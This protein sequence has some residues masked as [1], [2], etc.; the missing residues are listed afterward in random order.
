MEKTIYRISFDYSD[1]DGILINSHSQELRVITS[2]QQYALNDKVKFNVQLG[3]TDDKRDTVNYNAI[4]QTLARNPTY[5]VRNPDGSLFEVKDWEYENPVGILTERENNNAG[6][7][8]FGNLGIDIYPIKSVKL[9]VTGGINR[10]RFLNGSYMPSYSFPMEKEGVS[11]SAIR[12][13]GNSIRST[14]ESTL[15]WKKTLGRHNVDL[16]GGYGYEYFVTEEFYASNSNFISDDV[17][18]NNL[19]MGTFLAEGRADMDSYKGESKLA[20]FFARAVY[21][22]ANKYFLSASIRR[23]GSSKFGDNRK[24]GTFPAISAAWDIS[25]EGFFEPLSGVFE[26]LK[27]RAGYGITGNQGM[28]AFYVPILRYDQDQGFFYYNGE[29]VRGYVPASNA[30]PNLQ[31]ETKAEFN[32]GLD[33]LSL[34]SRLSGAIDFYVRDTRDL[35][36]EY[37]VPVPPNLN[38]KMWANVGSMRNSG[39]EISINATPVKKS[40]FNWEVNFTFDY[41]KNKVMSIQ[42]DYYTLEYR[43]I[44]E[45]GA[46]GISA[47]THRLEEGE[48]IGNI[49]TYQFEKIDSLGKWVFADLDSSGGK[50]TGDRTVVG[51]GVPDFYLGMTNILR[52]G[53]FDLSFMLRGMFG[54]QIIN[55]KRIWHENPQFLPSNIM[56]SAMYT[57]LWD[58]PEF[59]SYYVENGDFV[60]VDNITLGYTYGFKNNKYL[61]SFRLYGT[62][63]NAFVFTKYT[64]LD[65]EVSFKGLEPGNDNRFD[66]PSV[67]TF[68]VGLNVKF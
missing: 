49:H 6:S 9:N 38:S 8:L 11:G 27:I 56:K 52:Y 67:R 7:R 64:G 44:G 66:Y 42:N 36:L 50:S 31:W 59:S 1:Q 54:H 60:K 3:L 32:L 68:V 2:L 26:F 18:Y 62:V 63:N 65:P 4:R 37:D 30:N 51:N 41:R 28:T 12:R 5:P 22:Y 43:N 25:Q 19:G 15:E 20:G 48:P 21:S 29:Q 45:I 14:F 61:R 35:L 55:A 40:K 34:N 33:W 53:N 24:W 17:T 39:I 10:Y 58:S 57:N 23:E 46:P 47:W 16:L 13:A